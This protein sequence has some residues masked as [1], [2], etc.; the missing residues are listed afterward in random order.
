MVRA[1]AQVPVPSTSANPNP[2]PNPNYQLPITNTNTRAASYRVLWVNKSHML[3]KSIKRV[4][5]NCVNATVPNV[6]N[7][8]VA[9][10]S[11]CALGLLPSPV[12]PHKHTNRKTQ[13]QHN[14]NTHGGREQNQR[15][16][17]QHH[18]CLVLLLYPPFTG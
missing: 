5:R 2:N 17:N 8:F 1:V 12:E 11:V 18:R 7:R 10:S 14:N 4:C 16:Y 6:N 15:E 9:T 3:G 13:Q